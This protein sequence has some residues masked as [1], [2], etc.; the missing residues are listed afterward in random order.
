MACTVEP[1]RAVQGVLA[2]ST[3]VAS[4]A[5]PAAV[6]VAGRTRRS[7]RSEA[8]K[9]IPLAG[10]SASSSLAVAAVSDTQASVAS[11]FLASGAQL[12]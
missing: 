2:T 8:D 3:V 12:T 1:A 6:E 7:G 11:A 5:G 9:D 10:R 4:A